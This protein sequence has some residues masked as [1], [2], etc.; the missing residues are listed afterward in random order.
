MTLEI[1]ATTLKQREKESQC[2]VADLAHEGQRFKCPL[3]RQKCTLYF[4]YEQPI[5]KC[6]HATSPCN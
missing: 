3:A 2:A 4:P 5:F 6:D 1:R